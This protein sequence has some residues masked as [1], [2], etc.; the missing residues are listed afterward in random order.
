MLHGGR[1]F[2]TVMKLLGHT[3]SGMTMRY[4][5]VKLDRSPAR[6]STGSFKARH[7]PPQPKASPAAVRTRL[8]GHIDFL[9]ATQRVL[10][11]FRRPLL[12]GT[13]RTTVDGLSNWLTKILTDTRR[14]RPL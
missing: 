4:V 5:D 13:S 10:E 6:V 3:D 14:L 1:G 9:L 7:L 2:A 12:S 11:M 8:D